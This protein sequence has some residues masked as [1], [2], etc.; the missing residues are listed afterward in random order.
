MALR[1]GGDYY[2][3]IIPFRG[4]W[5][6]IKKE[7]RDLVKTLIYPV[8]DPRYPW[9]GVHFTNKI[10][11]EVWLGPN[12]ILATAREGYKVTDFSWKDFRE[13]ISYL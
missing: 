3:T 4:E 9:L 2:P 13:T 12:A 5:F 11:G 8:P 10:N 7:H 1:V 6:K